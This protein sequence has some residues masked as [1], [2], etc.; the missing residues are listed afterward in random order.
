M[1]L[2]LSNKLT[3]LGMA[4]A[5][6]GVALAAPSVASADLSGNIGVFSKYVLR[7]ITNATEND[8][9]TVQGGFDYSH[10]S[11]LYAGYW[12]SNLGYGNAMTNTGF[13]NDIYGGYAG[14]TNGVSYNVGLIQYYYIEVDDSDGLE[15]V[16]SVGYGPVKAGF[17]YLT[18]DVAWGNT[19]DIYWTVDY[20]A[21]LPMEF[22][23]G[24][25]LGYYTYEESGDFIASSA[26]DSAFRHLNLTLSHPVGTTGADMSITYVIGGEDRQGTDQEDTVVLGLTYGFEV[27]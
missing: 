9:T 1:K 18:N 2:R 4:T 12:G 23:F 19:G 26:N 13:E 3:T 24:A 27:K 8:S 25:S 22:G 7:G 11:G 16:G 15:F 6:A 21:S 20:S 5:L 14:E 10:A 17:K